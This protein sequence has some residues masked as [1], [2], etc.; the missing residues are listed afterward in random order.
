[1]VLADPDTSDEEEDDDEDGEESSV[2]HG[3]ISDLVEL[4]SI[5]GHISSG[6]SSVSTS[7]S[8][9]GSS[10]Q[11][12]TAASSGSCGSGIAGEK[13]ARLIK[14]LETIKLNADK[15]V[16]EKG[17]CAQRSEGAAQAECD[18]VSD[19]ER[20]VNPKSV[21]LHAKSAAEFVER[22]KMGGTR[23]LSLR[24]TTS[25]GPR[26][27]EPA[28]KDDPKDVGVQELP[29]QALGFTRLTFIVEHVY[30]GG[31]LQS[32]YTMCHGRQRHKKQPH[33]KLHGNILLVS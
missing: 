10:S 28:P 1:M 9:V 20:Q 32:L 6:A 30:A 8:T 16:C 4:A 23:A 14:Q 13:L 25:E 12:S 21:S 24:K 5:S 33:V 11:V 15:A 31:I 27:V 29:P 19:D 7:A 17:C 3:D 18:V 22:P 26:V 2:A